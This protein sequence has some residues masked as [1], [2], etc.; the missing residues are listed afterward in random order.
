MIYAEDIRRTILI[1]AEELGK[2][3]NFDPSDIAKKI[4]KE[5]WFG[6]L[7]HVTMVVEVLSKEGKIISEMHNGECRYRKN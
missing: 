7:P 2:D 5:N 4:D 3:D 1:V 6:L